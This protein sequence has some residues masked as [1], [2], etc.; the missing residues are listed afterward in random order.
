M[1]LFKKLSTV[2]ITAAIFTTAAHPASAISLSLGGTNN[3]DGQGYKSSVSGA[4]TIDFNNGVAPIS[5]FATYSAANGTPTIVQGNSVNQYAA[6]VGDNSNYLTI[7]PF[8]SSTTNVAGATGPVTIQFAQALDYFGLDWGSLDT[9]NYIDF[10][11]SGTQVGHFDGTAVGTLSA[12]TAGVPTAAFA[13]HTDPTANFYANFFADQGQTFDKVVLGSTGIAFESD[14]HA[15]RAV[16]EPNSM[17]GL[18]AVG[19]FGVSV[20][21]KR[22]REQRA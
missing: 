19:T 18:L 2:A 7:S 12:K 1:T 21:L 13:D 20:L 9:Y 11:S 3:N 16:P 22:K 17:A 6:P 15:Y 4:T 5:G 10:Y 8:S 14:N